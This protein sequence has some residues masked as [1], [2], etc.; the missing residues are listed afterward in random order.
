MFRNGY[1]KRLRAVE[2]SNNI[3]FKKDWEPEK[4]KKWSWFTLETEAGKTAFKTNFDDYLS[5]T[6]AGLVTRVPTKGPQ[7]LFEIV[8]MCKKGKNPQILFF[9]CSLK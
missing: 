4:I 2:N 1:G 8:D 5:V 3:D 9:K 7:E 6:E